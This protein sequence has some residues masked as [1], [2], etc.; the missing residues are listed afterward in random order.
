VCLLA[1]MYCF[2]GFLV[3]EH[4]FL[5]A[6]CVR[7]ANFQFFWSAN[8]FRRGECASASQN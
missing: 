2:F 8:L 4:D 5:L 1:G 7:V 6:T 3:G